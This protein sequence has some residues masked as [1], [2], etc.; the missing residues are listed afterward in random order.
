M[1]LGLMI[2][3]VW[4]RGAASHGKKSRPVTCL[5]RDA[6]LCPTASAKRY[7]R[8]LPQDTVDGQ[9]AERVRRCSKFLRV[10]PNMRACED[11]ARLP[12]MRT[13]TGLTS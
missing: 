13:T 10:R 4:G 8:S 7:T 3:I 11:N 1:D 2:M 9:D 6:R 12:N 5:A